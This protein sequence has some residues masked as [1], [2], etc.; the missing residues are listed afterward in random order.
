MKNKKLSLGLFI[1]FGVCFLMLAFTIIQ[2]FSTRDAFAYDPRTAEIQS[3][4]PRAIAGFL[5]TITSTLIF[6]LGA[7]GMGV[8][9]FFIK[10]LTNKLNTLEETNA[11]LLKASGKLGKF[12]EAFREHAN[13]NAGMEEI[14]SKLEAGEELKNTGLQ[15]SSMA[16]R[17][18]EI[19]SLT[20]QLSSITEQMEQL[21]SSS[22]NS[23]SNKSCGM[24]EIHIRLSAS[25]QAEY[26]TA[27]ML[28]ISGKKIIDL[29]EKINNGEEQ[30]KNAHDIIKAASVDLE[31]ITE[32]ANV[33]NQIAEQTNILS[34]NAA[35]ESAHA[36]AAGAGFAVVSDE[37]RKLAD[38]TKENA[39]GIQAVLLVITS[40]IT[41]ALKA[42]EIS[43]ETFGKIT[44]EISDFADTI[45]AVSENT[46]KNCATRADINTDLAETL[47]ATNKTDYNEAASLRDSLN[48]SITQIRN[49]CGE[50]KTISDKNNLEAEEFRAKL[51]KGLEEI[52]G[53]L[54]N[55]E[56]LKK[57]LISADTVVDKTDT[58][59]P[60]KTDNSWRKDVDVKSPPRT[61]F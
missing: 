31:K 5:L 15:A 2:L 1:V 14:I 54:K 48:S 25:Q 10:G 37:I 21:I 32:I 19:E 28:D 61:V 30:S 50:A 23:G 22:Q 49:Y 17:F 8:L 39:A 44:A 24:K 42:S 3:A 45:G 7:A 16:Q 6:I 53:Y 47:D 43:S 60:E 4:D 56:K 9:L 27:E 46:R 55:A 40:Q 26:S 34:M 33:I 18:E 59:T 35:I 57:M 38:S 13:S 51:E 52:H 58:Q 29:K 12:I 20:K 11:E 41:G 36:G